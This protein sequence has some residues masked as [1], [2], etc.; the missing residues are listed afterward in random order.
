MKQAIR[1]SILMGGLVGTLIVAAVPQVPAT[2]GG[3]ILVWPPGDKNCQINLPPMM[4]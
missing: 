1:I 2:D 4:S 3:T